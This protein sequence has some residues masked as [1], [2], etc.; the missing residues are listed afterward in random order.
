MKNSYLTLFLILFSAF[1][2]AQEPFVTTWQVEDGDLQI[3]ISDANNTSDIYNYSIDFGDGVV[4]NNVTG[5]ISHTFAQAGTYTVSISGVFPRI[6]FS[7]SLYN[8]RLKI[9]SVEQW[10]DIQWKS[11]KNAFS[12]C[13][14]LIINATDSPNLSQVTSLELMFRGATNLNQSLNNWDVSNISN[15]SYMFQY[16]NSFNQPLN[17]WDVSNVTNMSGMF[18]D[19]NSFNQPIG[20]WNVSN[21]TEMSYLF[22]SATNFNQNIDLWDVSNVE[23]MS[24]MF[25]DA[26]SF[27]Q[28]LNNWNV[29]NVTS[30]GEMFKNAT[31][32][33]QPL[34]NWNLDSVNF[35]QEIFSGATSFD[36]PLNNW[37]FPNVSR[38]DDIFY[39]A[40]SFNGAINEW[41][42]SNIS[43]MENLF[44]G[45][46]SFN[47][48]LENWNVSNVIGMFGIFRGASSFN[49][50]LNNWDI[51][52]VTSLGEAFFEASNFN[53]P[54]DNWNVQN[55]TNMQK[56]FSG[57]IAFNQPIG[58]WN[59]ANVNNLNQTFNNAISF[60][61]LINDWD[62]S[63]VQTMVGTFSGASSFNQPLDNW[64][65][66]N[67]YSMSSLFNGAIQFNQD[68]SNWDISN[69]QQLNFMFNNAHSFN[70]DISN[71]Q[72][73]D[74]LY[75]HDF[76]N[77]SGLDSDNYDALLLNFFNLGIQ[78]S[79]FGQNT[80]LGARELKFCDI[81]TRTN[82]INN[83]WTFIGDSLSNECN[84]VSGVVYYDQDENGCTVLDINVNNIFVN[85][86]SNN[87]SNAKL[88]N[89]S[90]YILYTSDNS[91]TLSIINIPDYFT[92]TPQSTTV[93]FSITSTEQVDFCLTANQTIE[94][95]NIKL[96]PIADARP[97]FEANYKLIIENRGT[98]MINN[99]SASVLFDDAKQS[100]ISATPAESS[101][102]SNRL[103]FSIASLNPFAKHEIN[104]VMQTF[105]PPTVNSDD[106]LNFTASVLPS[107]NDYSPDNN[108]YDL[109]QIVVNSFDPNDKRVVQGNTITTDETSNYLDYIIRFQNT[110]S[111]N[112]INVKITD[113]LH[114]NLDWST[115][116]VTSASHDYNVNLISLNIV[117]G[118]NVEFS[119]D[120]INL[121]SEMQNEP[122]SHG[123]IAYKIK[124]INSIGEG[125]V[126]SG[127][128]SIY[129]DYNL[130]IITNTVSTEVVNPL[131][132]DE[133]FIDNN[134]VIYPN[135]AVDVIFIKKKSNTQ[136]HSV[137][138]YNI[139]GREL[140]NLKGNINYIDTR[141]IASGAYILKM[142]TNFGNLNKQIIIE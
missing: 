23:N 135:P 121:P 83:G 88:V 110:G 94:D 57:A 91:L 95:L 42:V 101:A 125:D 61:Q 39:N 56:M 53:Q 5:D 78:P 1:V 64:N 51:S 115:L 31:S 114:P 24:L 71:W 106:V 17:N 104:L 20:S 36:Q 108:T 122:E 12:G 142:E 26:T 75:L 134:V 120:N 11:M 41:D 68:I 33:N 116:S 85:A 79:S 45:A 128:A 2:Q 27:N 84:S 80:G 59:V 50:S 22:Y 97:G 96:L 73:R 66:V 86:Y 87:I 99:I 10:G 136:L 111:A 103:D 58:N 98:E 38:L 82:L 123:Y 105:A 65:I 60:N 139:Q 137:K 138:L 55:V 14:N 34:N 72:F 32:F 69:V 40:V 43:Y 54:L 19:A 102:S 113:N 49:Q 3:Q 46:V 37:R 67:V 92:A 117:N 30:M 48:P 18:Y 13:S 129:F 7:N 131:S 21:V 126:M 89:E 29:S 124:P 25:R 6:V 52:N 107:M 112:A 81:D 133:F 109:E 4:E 90:E 63:N 8:S 15:M 132:N 35:L 62:V 16:A 44:N 77:F 47:Q 141:E 127:N 140:I 100:F 118:N 93:D 119:F 70:Q 130:P 28:S 74:G 9:R 76:L